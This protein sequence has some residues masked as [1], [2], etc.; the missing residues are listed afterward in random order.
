M[1]ETLAERSARLCNSGASVV[2][3][4]QPVRSAITASY[5]LR[6]MAKRESVE[7]AVRSVMRENAD[8][9]EDLAI[10]V[11]QQ[12]AKTNR[13]EAAVA[14]D[15]QLRLWTGMTL[16]DLAVKGECGR[17]VERCCDA[18]LT[19][20][21]YGDLDPFTNSYSS[22]LV[23]M[24]FGGLPCVVWENF[25]SYQPPPVAEVK[26]G[27]TQR[28]KR[29]LG[30]PFKP[31]NDESGRQKTN[32]RM[33]NMNHAALN[34]TWKCTFSAYERWELFWMAPVVLYLFNTL[35]SLAVTVLF[36]EHFVRRS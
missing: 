19:T 6:Q 12:A 29:P 31:P 35:L 21:L 5:L 28:R 14:L 32:N 20:R 23:N 27:A 11:M 30:Y 24:I 34:E 17:F 15:C 25:L 26:R 3:R 22:I 18:A 33:A 4:S 13:Q 7:P 10:G 9:F 8:L 16:L 36:T 2:L 1:G